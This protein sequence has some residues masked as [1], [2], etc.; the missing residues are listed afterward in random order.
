MNGST[1]ASARVEVDCALWVDPLRRIWTSFG[2]DGLNWTATPRGL[3]NLA[4]LR[5][6]ME[7][8]CRLY[9]V[10][11]A[12]VTDALP[13]ARVGGPATTGGGVAFL[14][15]FLAHCAEGTNAVTGGRGTR[16]D[17]V[18]FH[19]KGAA[20]HI[21]DSHSNSYAAWVAEGRPQNPGPGQL[22]ALRAH[23]GLELYGPDREF[24]R[25]PEHL[26]LSFDLPLPGV[27]LLELSSAKENVLI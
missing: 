1:A 3:Q 14:E 4:T 15:R 24:T 7:D 6:F 19:T 26:E 21:D 27:S 12:A 20:F 23:D 5:S 8:Y 25:A 2:Y 10:T 9:D 18:S 11:V 22:A 17:F 13:E 16:L